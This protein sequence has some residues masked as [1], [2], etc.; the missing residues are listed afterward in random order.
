MQV[1]T[2][3]IE[4]RAPV[5]SALG[6][7]SPNVAVP[8]PEVTAA[9]DVDVAEMP[10]LSSLGI[11]LPELHGAHSLTFVEGLLCGVRSGRVVCMGD[12]AAEAMRGLSKLRDVVKLNLGGEGCVVDT[13]G[14]VKCFA[15]EPSPGSCFHSGSPFEAGTVA[16]GEPVA[17][18][19]A[20]PS[21]SCAVLRN[22]RSAC[23]RTVV[24]TRAHCEL[25]WWPESEHGSEALL[26]SRASRF[27]CS[28][29]ANGQDYYDAASRLDREGT[30]GCWTHNKSQTKLSEVRTLPLDQPVVELTT[31]LD[32]TICARLRNGD[33]RCSGPF[34]GTSN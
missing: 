1:P 10:V 29:A 12:R 16:I 31:G 24:T 5:G 28:L 4:F 30:I 7:A 21:D 9:S 22:G 33:V 6:G 25:D 27:A 32:D 26:R 18:V 3:G 20:S 11:A 23:W 14:T 2:H 17:W 34:S 13:R 19:E 15:L 8:N